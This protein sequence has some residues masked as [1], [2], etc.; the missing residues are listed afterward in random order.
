[1]NT[2]SVKTKN[3]VPLVIA[4][5]TVAG[6]ILGLVVGFVVFT[7]PQH[8]FGLNATEAETL[9]QSVFAGPYAET[10]NVTRDAANQTEGHSINQYMEIIINSTSNFSGLGEKIQ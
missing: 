9:K 5:S 6:F 4:I 2:Q 8:V 10:L 3:V 7:P 1:M